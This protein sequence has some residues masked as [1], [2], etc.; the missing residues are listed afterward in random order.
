MLLR[1]FLVALA[2]PLLVATSARAQ[3][4]EVPLYTDLGSHHYAITTR[5]PLAQ[6]YFD[7]G[8]RLYYAFNHAEAIRSFA[9]AGRLDSACAMC[10]WGA[11]L[12][13]GPNVNAAMAPDAYAPAHAD[14]QKALALQ[15][16]ATPLERALIRALAVRYAP[17]APADRAPLDSAYARAMAQVVRE[18]P[19]DA[20]AAALYAEALMD[21]SPWNYW[22]RGEPRPDTP[23]LVGR[24]ERVIAARPDH[25]GA[26]HFYIHAVEAVHPA[27]A[28][29]C[30][31]RLAALMPGAGH[32][33]HMPGH[34][35]IR[36]GRYLDAIRANEH[37]VHADEAYIRDQRP[38]A[39]AY[40]LGY[41]P[42]NYDFLAFAAAMAGRGDQALQASRTL[43]SLIP[44][45]M[46]TD[47]AMR[48]LQHHLVR[49]MQ[50]LVRLERWD[51][52]LQA[53]A[54]PEQLRHSR[55]LWHYARGRAL[56][57]KGD[58][59]GAEAELAKVQAAA[60]DSALA[61]MRLEFNTSPAILGI[62][63]EV[64]A[65]TIA[66]KRGSHDEA[67]RRLTEAARREDE[68]LY[69]EPP[70]WSVPVRHDL[71]A[72]YL[73]AGRPAE[74]ERV[75][76]EDLSR[77]PENGWALTGLAKALRDQGR[78]AEAGEAQARLRAAWPDAAITDAHHGGGHH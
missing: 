19:D 51:E 7:Q 28:V 36:V 61:G 12:A 67:V 29:P 35:Y 5:V 6:R 69:G 16:G 32:L 31:E 8:L 56:A 54:P 15:A 46:L 24:L 40:T 65:G 18:F 22:T 43:A 30:A 42:H 68:L 44:V 37:A 62:A 33:V 52:I 13:R 74:A 77:F 3:G 10:H 38:A 72:A 78:T 57:A 41:Y 63:A 59:A 21:L 23:E 53:P 20:E 76:R 9:E 47:P 55:A 58:V 2:A 39:G 66:S 14:A 75:Y 48:H 26:C 50:M 4:G 60:A 45:E 70:E 11:A 64:L 25:P 71:G 49:P 17:S 27:R 34:I 73:A 1:T